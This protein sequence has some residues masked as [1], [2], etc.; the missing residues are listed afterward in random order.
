MALDHFLTA[1]ADEKLRRVARYVMVTGDEGIESLDPVDKTK[2]GEELESAVHSRR[3]RAA[4]FGFEAL[5]EV[6]GLDRPA[7]R[8]NELIDVLAEIGE[9]STARGTHFLGTHHRAGH[10]LRAGWDVSMVVAV[11]MIL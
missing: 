5:E 3:L 6:I 9:A 7:I 11:C 1:V 4:L 2:F 10:S 8:Q